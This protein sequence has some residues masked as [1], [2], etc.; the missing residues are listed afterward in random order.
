MKK[1]GESVRRKTAQNRFGDDDD[2]DRDEEQGN[3]TSSSSDS[4]A[5]PGCINIGAAQ[6]AQKRKG[7][8]NWMMLVGVLALLCLGAIVPYIVQ[9]ALPK[10]EDG[11]EDVP[12]ALPSVALQ[13]GGAGAALVGTTPRQAPPEAPSILPQ[14]AAPPQ[15]LLSEGMLSTRALKQAVRARAA[16]GKIAL[17]ETIK[18]ELEDSSD[19]VVFIAAKMGVSCHEACVKEAGTQR[20]CAADWFDALNDCTVLQAA[21]PSSGG[22]VTHYYG[23]DLPAY[24]DKAQGV[25][26]GSEVMINSRMAEYKTGCDAVGRESRRLC[27]CRV[28]VKTKDSL[29]DR[30]SE[31][32]LQQLKEKKT[33]LDASGA[34]G[35]INE[36]WAA[37]KPTDLIDDVEMHRIT[38]VDAPLDTNCH[39]TCQNHGL[40]CQRH[41]FDVLNNCPA[42]Q[43]AFPSNTK[44]SDEVFG[45]DLPA[46]RPEDATVLVNQQPRTWTASCGHRHA[47]TQRLCG[48][49]FSKDG[50]ST[51]RTF[52]TVYN[53]QA[54]KYFEWQVRYMKMWF[55]QAG[56]P[57][58]LT[59]LL[60]AG[61]PDFLAATGEIATHTSPPYNRPGDFYTPYNKPWSVQRWLEDEKPTED[62]IMIIDPDCMFVTKMELVVEEGSPIAQQAFY[63]FDFNKNDVPMQI[64]RRYCKDCTFLDPIAVPII[65]HRHDIQKI[66][67]KWLSKTIEIRQ[68]MANWPPDWNNRTRSPV[69]LG[70]TAEMFGYVFAAS[71]L[72]IR[73]EIWDLQ[74]VPPVHK[75][76]TTNII[77]YHVEVPIPDGKGTQWWKHS[78]DA[79]YNIPWPLPEKT[80]EVTRT[81]ISKLHEAYGKLGKTSHEWKTP[82]KYVAEV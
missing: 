71:E 15:I 63:H 53:V 11:A 34:V 75:K 49:G 67:P 58:K 59:R 27:P 44:C 78:D 43:A 13:G 40:A 26:R 79:G 72:G 73:H 74:N 38:F 46:Y 52:H 12:N 62:V 76:L 80:D 64:A 14:E 48:C 30:L 68:D 9:L 7:N 41:W 66:A 8:N 4:D 56:V 57:G 47:K 20:T 61:V 37:H 33:Q 36:W 19:A 1:R 10:G 54:S 55:E 42:L 39:L 45:R 16:E 51:S 82:N 81:L 35:G 23:R 32:V 24:T 21:F 22:C 5:D 29:N 6:G 31:V 18:G 3:F 28:T 69:G 25:L 17:G 2:D 65:I 50:S 60:S 70:W 77:H